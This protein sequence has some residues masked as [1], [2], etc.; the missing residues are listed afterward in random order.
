MAVGARRRSGPSSQY[1]RPTPLRA[2]FWHYSRCI[3]ASRLARL[4]YTRLWWCVSCWA[5]FASLIIGYP[6]GAHT[7]QLLDCQTA[8]PHRAA[9]SYL[10]TRYTRLCSLEHST[11]SVQLCARRAVKS[12]CVCWRWRRQPGRQR[13]SL[14]ARARVMLCKR[15][16]SNDALW[17]SLAPV[18][19]LLLPVHACSRQAH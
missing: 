4:G 18:L 11:G 7:H 5:V 9:A 19:L 2:Y 16:V 8:H 12:R 14:H 6:Q 10:H 13:A 15:H 17:T 1:C 3:H